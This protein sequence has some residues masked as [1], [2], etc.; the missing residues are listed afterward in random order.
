MHDVI[1]TTLIVLHI[2]GS[3]EFRAILVVAELGFRHG[4]LSAKW[5]CGT[6]AALLY[7]PSS[8][9]LLPRGLHRSLIL[10][11]F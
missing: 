11:Y 7:F 9:G 8:Y 3:V 5:N 6:G 2:L 10:I 1:K 4:S